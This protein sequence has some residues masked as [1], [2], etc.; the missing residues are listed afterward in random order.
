MDSMKK[1]VGRVGG[2]T[3]CRTVEQKATTLIAPNPN[4]P[5]GED[6]VANHAHPFVVEGIPFSLLVSH[7]EQIESFFESEMS[8]G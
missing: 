7:S 1:P 2:T 4:L 8:H 5:A 6:A 3:L